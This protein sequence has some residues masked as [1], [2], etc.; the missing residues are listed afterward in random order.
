MI[1]A[2]IIATLALAS[3]LTFRAS[4]AYNGAQGDSPCSLPCVSP[5][6][7][8][9]GVN[10]NANLDGRGGPLLGDGYARDLLTGRIERVTLTNSGSLGNDTSNVVGFSAEGRF[11]VI[12]SRATNLVDGDTNGFG[13]IFVRDR[14][15][16]TTEMVSLTHDGQLANGGSEIPS[17]SGDGRFVAFDSNATNLV[18]NDT[19]GK[20]DIF[21]RDRWL[22]TTVRV[23]ISST[24]EQADRD[25]W[26][27]S[28]SADGRYVVFQTYARNLIPDDTNRFLD[29]YLH[30]MQTG[31]TERVSIASDGTEGNG[32]SRISFGG[33][34][35]SADGRYVCFG[36]TAS[37]LVSGDTNRVTDA[38]VR[39][40]W[41]GTTTRVSVRSDG[42][43]AN[44]GGGSAAITSEGRYVLIGSP[45]TNLTDDGDINDRLLDV[46]MHDMWTGETW[47]ISNNTNGEQGNAQ[48]EASVMSANGMIVAFASN[49]TNLA[50]NDTNGFMD[51]FVHINAMLRR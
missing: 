45:S 22:E 4:L 37:N 20:L 42:G 9:I 17:I 2:S 10:T 8:Y 5:D 25:S 38:F 6:G 35:M 43:Q 33:T 14:L 26:G 47:R 40:R 23:S 19:N 31:Q 27:A 7:R 28:I 18:P 12:S 11:A 30:D 21:V 34:Q 15:L 36:S 39:D 29:V 51:I 32:E 13:D 50:P 41:F 24:G 49:A 48:S 3:E 16:R 44:H 46:F 1:G